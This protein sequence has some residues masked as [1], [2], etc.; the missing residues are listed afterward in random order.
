LTSHYYLG[1]LPV[2][3]NESGVNRYTSIFSGS[4]VS[5]MRGGGTADPTNYYGNTTHSW[6]N[7]NY[8]TQ[9]MTLNANGL[10][11]LDLADAYFLGSSKVLG[12][13]TGVNNYT[14]I[15]SGSGVSAV[16]VGGS[17]DPHTYSGNTTHSW[18]TLNY[19]A[20]LLTLD[21]SFL[22]LGTNL[23]LQ[24]AA[25]SGATWTRGFITESLTLSTVGLTTDTTLNLLPAG[26]LIE[27]V[28]CRVTTA[29]TLTTN[30]AVGDPTTAARFSAANA[31]LAAGTTSVGIDQW[32]GAVTTL[33]AGPSQ[34]ANAKVRITCTGANPGAGVIHIT[35]FYRSFTP[36]TS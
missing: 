20:L 26:A 16:R 11:I 14:S 17:A 2:L 30:W 27:A 28:C 7:L 36:P 31:T 21:S 15:Y 9:W 6:H 4:G 13:E 29:I 3:G 18:H 23:S 22:T 8:G 32:S 5:V 25:G 10:N 24:Q 33:A 1:G 34:A 35:T 12:N 19:A